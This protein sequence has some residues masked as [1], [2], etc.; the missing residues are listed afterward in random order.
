[1]KLIDW[2]VPKKFLK[3]YIIFKM[4]N[5]F[6][7]WIKFVCLSSKIGEQNQEIEYLRQNPSIDASS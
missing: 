2:L 1:M 6:V 7:L 4:I 5:G 3:I